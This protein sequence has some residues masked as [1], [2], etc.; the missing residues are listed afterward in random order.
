M[1]THG[2]APNVGGGPARARVL[3]VDDDS[4]MRMLC[5]INLQLEGLGVL[6]ASDGR[7]GLALA[8]SE[9]PDVVVTDVSMPTLDGFQLAEALHLDRSTRRIPLIFLSG[10][11]TAANRDR[12]REL[13]A[14]AYLT[15]PFDPSAL[16]AVVADALALARTS[17]RQRRAT[18]RRTRSPA[19]V[20]TKE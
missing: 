11:A 6:E 18:G 1:E 2:A 5:A 7:H 13:G 16:A 9:R 20:A 3:L 15:K 10:E 17:R 12:A 8:R 19:V 14:H 4:A